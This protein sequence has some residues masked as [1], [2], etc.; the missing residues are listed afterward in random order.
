MPSSDGFPA[1]EVSFNKIM[2]FMLIDRAV[3]T[4]LHLRAVISMGCAEC[5]WL[6][7]FL[8]FTPSRHIHRFGYRLNYGF[9]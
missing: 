6:K 8:I 7:I 9:A 5:S 4:G 2:Y 1:E 3:K